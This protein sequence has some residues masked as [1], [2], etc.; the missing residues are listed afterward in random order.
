MKN[1]DLFAL[2]ENYS[3]KS[4]EFSMALASEA[5]YEQLQSLFLELQAIF[6]ELEILSQQ[7]FIQLRLDIS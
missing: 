2:Q 4:Q 6:D 3:R 5:S 1:S 7:K